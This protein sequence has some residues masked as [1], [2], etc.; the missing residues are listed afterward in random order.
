MWVVI[1]G[2]GVTTLL[3]GWLLFGYIIWLRFVGDMRKVVDVMPTA[4]HPRISIIVPCLN[5]ESLIAEKC[6]NLLE[7]SYPAD[8]MEIVFA[9]GGSSDRTTE[10]LDGF[11]LRDDRVR[12]TKCPVGGKINQLNHVLPGLGGDIVFVTD[13]DARLAPDALTHMVAEF[14]A[15]PKMAV[16]GG[17]TSPRGGLVVERCFWAA[18][19]RVRL[20]ESSVSH[21][22][23][24]VACCYAF[25][26]EL[27]DAFPEDVIADD[28]YVAALANTAGYHTTYCDKAMVEE[29]RTAGT[30]PEFFR[31]KFR[32]S[33]AV[34]R[35]LLRFSYRL[36][37][38][39]A[40]WR[41]VL[42][43]R[44]L[45]QLLLPWAT[46]LWI[47]LW[48]ALLNAG[49]IDVPCLGVALLLTA[50]LATRKAAVS[51]ELPGETEHFSGV[52]VALAYL[53][54][55][56]VLFATGLTYVSFRQ[57]SCYARL[58]ALT[59]DSHLPQVVGPIRTAARVEVCPPLV[60]R[61]PVVL[62]SVD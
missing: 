54:T 26:R 36:P 18:Q 38:M 44:I 35:E 12:V 10:I 55:M 46:G 30:L 22:S 1:L 2:F 48:A 23:L 34:L 50:L 13:A 42:S 7:T 51:V 56:A 41:S 39:N 27:L 4:S 32:K 20:L 28:V 16:V 40:R 45:Q 15:N 24:V 31:H 53:Y 9:D 52:T 25:R 6:R 59:S 58:G 3:L 5:E 57:S 62:G 49:Q 21:V 47:A 37:D 17:Y 14:E 43:T 19:N 29:L 60:D 8:R 33:N 61:V 11:A